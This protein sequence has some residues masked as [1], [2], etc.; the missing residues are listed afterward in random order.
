MAIPSLIF[1]RLLKR[2]IDELV[3]AMEQEAMKLVEY[4]QGN[5]KRLA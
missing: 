4:L 3:V 1:Y 2:K 5:R